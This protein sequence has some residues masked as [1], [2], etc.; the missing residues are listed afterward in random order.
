MTTGSGESEEMR[1]VTVLG[2]PLPEYDGAAADGGAVGVEAPRVD[3][4][5][6]DGVE[7]TLPI[8]G[9]PTL[10]AVMAHWCPHCQREAPLLAEWARSGTIPA[11]VEIAAVSTAYRP[12]LVGS[13]AAEAVQEPSQW[14]ADAAVPFAVLADDESASA[15][16]ALGVNG[17]PTFVMIDGAGNLAWRTSGEISIDDLSA[18]VRQTLDEVGVPVESVDVTDLATAGTGMLALGVSSVE[19][20]TSKPLVWS[21]PDGVTWRPVPIVFESDWAVPVAAFAASDG[22][23]YVFGHQSFDGVVVPVVWARAGSADAFTT[24]YVGG[25]AARAIGIA[26][27]ATTD[28][29]IAVRDDGSPLVLE[30]SD[31]GITPITS[32]APGDRVSD[33]RTPASLGGV[34]VAAVSIAGSTRIARSEDD[35]RTWT[36]EELSGQSTAVHTILATPTSLIAIGTVGRSVVEVDGTGR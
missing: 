28:L 25:S 31:A 35:G 8:S 23:D 24:K 7:L 27:T 22:T 14:L 9:T 5:T 13:I 15:A 21:S 19:E 3:G 12:G 26:S 20:Q 29:L 11:G 2:D 32:S 34:V 1:P 6:F 33:W 18:R 30:V 16:Q 17:F 10:I 4:Q 36:Y